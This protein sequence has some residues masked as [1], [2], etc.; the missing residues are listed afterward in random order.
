MQI[1]ILGFAGEGHA[2]YEY[3][4]RDGNSITICDVDP[5]TKVPKE[6]KARLGKDYLAGLDAY[7]V[8]VR[9]P[10]L[11]PKDIVAANPK[12]KDILN[13]VTTG[14]NEFFRVCPTKNIIGVTGT[15]GK[16][17][18]STL[19]TKM[20]EAAGKRVHL[21]G[22]IGIPPLDLLK[23]NIKLTDW[24]VLE[25]SNFQLI[26]LHSSPPMGVCL[27]I[28]PEHLNWHETIDEYLDTKRQLFRH[29]SENDV[30]IYYGPNRY[31]L[32]IAEASPGVL[33][34]FM[35]PPGAVVVEDEKVVIEGVDICSVDDIRLLGKHNWQNVCAAVTVAWQITHDQQALKKAI[36]AFPGLPHRLEFVREVDNVRYFNDSYAS[37]PGATIAALSAI[38]GKKIMIVGGLDR[39]LELQEMARA[40]V[41]HSDDVRRVVIIGAAGLRLEKELAAHAFTNYDLLKAKDLAE[42]V[43]HAK[44]NAQNGDSVV[45]SPG[46][47]SFDMFKNFEERGL[48]FKKI[49]NS[50]T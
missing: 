36:S 44:A 34:P 29:Q 11:H 6:A 24:V 33:M 50:L 31:S 28:E 43:Q 45:L 7:D 30:A 40:F 12:N 10:S 32:S 39:G 41:K 47:A 1:A 9:T 27:M 15:K 3:W 14:T 42:I 17:T 37:A 26:D 49:V 20:L 16:G 18:T 25:L 5:D 19:I 21:G 35:A 8:L 23:N 46:F 4:N 13:K 2:A 48:K 22:N 38:E